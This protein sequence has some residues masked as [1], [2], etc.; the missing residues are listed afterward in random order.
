MYK[1]GYQIID[2][3]GKNFELP[4][5]AK[6]KG[7]YEKVSGT[8]KPIM[9]SDFTVGGKH[10][11]AAFVQATRNASTSDYNMLVANSTGKYLIT[12]TKND[13]VQIENV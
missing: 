10:E 7:V 9:I 3:S 6:F 12:I 2:I 8:T 4:G 13:M 5:S 11:R 1:G